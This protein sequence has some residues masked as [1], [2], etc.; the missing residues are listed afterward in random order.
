[1]VIKYKRLASSAFREMQVKTIYWDSIS[2]QSK[3]S[4]IKKRRNESEAGDTGKEEYSHSTK[5]PREIENKRVPYDPAMPL[6]GINSKDSERNTEIPTSLS[7]RSWCIGAHPLGNGWGKCGI[8]T[9]WRFIWFQKIEIMLLEGDGK[10]A[11]HHIEQNKLDL[12]WQ[13]LTLKQEGVLWDESKQ[14]WDGE[15]QKAMRRK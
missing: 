15:Y 3:F 10:T 5:L 6:L 14:S 8:L 4:A 9:Q 2:P 13:T 11:H 12:E 7:H 1:M